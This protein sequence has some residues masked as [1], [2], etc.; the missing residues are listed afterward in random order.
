MR[1]DHGVRG[2]GEEGVVMR[3]RGGEEEE[4]ARRKKNWT[5]GKEGKGPRRV[6]GPDIN[7][8]RILSIRAA[9]PPRAGQR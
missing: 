5:A 3:G 2:D 9:A 6:L 1:D 7:S 8:F 4:R